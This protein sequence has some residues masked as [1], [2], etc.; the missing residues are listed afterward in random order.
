MTIASRD[1]DLLVVRDA[2]VFEGYPNA[3]TEHAETVWSRVS[4]EQGVE[5]LPTADLTIEQVRKLMGPVL[6]AI[7]E[8]DFAVLRAEN[9]R[10]AD[11][12]AVAGDIKTLTKS[13][14]EVKDEYA[15]ASYAYVSIKGNGREARQRKQAA[16]D[17]KYDLGKRLEAL[18]EA[19]R[20]ALA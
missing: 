14:F 1:L 4:R 16:F 10:I 15:A 7:F 5:W 13:Y 12:A 3:T 19:I 8:E 2:L 9:E 11:E 6:E 17:L 20:A 18:E